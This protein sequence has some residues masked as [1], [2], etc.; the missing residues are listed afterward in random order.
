MFKIIWAI[1]VGIEIVF[2]LLV[3]KQR[4]MQGGL[5]PTFW[6]ILLAITVACFVI[7]I[8]PNAPK[9]LIWVA[10]AISAAPLVVALLFL[11]FIIMI[12]GW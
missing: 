4:D 8:L 12:A 3:V 2:L 11:L 7:L 6:S 9:W 1:F 10:T 5:P